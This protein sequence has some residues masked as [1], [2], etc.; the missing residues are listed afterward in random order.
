MTESKTGRATD[1]FVMNLIYKG[2]DGSARSF[3]EE[4]EKSGIADGV[5]AE[6]GNLRYEYYFSAADPES[7]LLIDQWEDQQALDAHHASEW[8]KKIMDLRE[9]YALTMSPRRFVEVPLP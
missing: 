7:V 6:D 4:M 8:M 2:K 9:K 5:R 3:V 1:S